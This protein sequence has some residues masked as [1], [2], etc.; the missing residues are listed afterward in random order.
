MSTHPY[1]NEYWLQAE[2]ETAEAMA[3]MRV[4][5]ARLSFQIGKQGTRAY[6]KRCM[7]ASGT[8]Y[9]P[10]GETVA[11]SAVDLPEEREYQRKAEE[12]RAQS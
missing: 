4:A 1:T 9:R 7:D 5:V 10:L 6:F 3:K 8:T 11:T 12:A 2:G